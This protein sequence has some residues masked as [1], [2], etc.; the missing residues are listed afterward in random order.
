MHCIVVREP[1][2]KNG[3]GNYTGGG[4]CPSNAVLQAMSQVSVCIRRFNIH[5]TQGIC[6]GTEQR[7][8]LD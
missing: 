2:L 3:V 7:Q 8:T 1:N 4:V 6:M 5:L